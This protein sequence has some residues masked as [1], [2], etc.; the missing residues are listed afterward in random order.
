MP[1]LCDGTS[2]FFSL[3]IE[4]PPSGFQTVLSSRI[5]A[6]A[7][8]NLYS[9]AAAARKYHISCCSAALQYFFGGTRDRLASLIYLDS[10]QWYIIIRTA[11]RLRSKLQETSLTLVGLALSLSQSLYALTLVLPISEPECLLRIRE[12]LP[13]I[14]PHRG[15]EHSHCSQ[16]SISLVVY[17][18]I[19]PSPKEVVFLDDVWTLFDCPDVLGCMLDHVTH[20]MARRPR[21]GQYF[22][23]CKNDESSSYCP[24][25]HQIQSI[26]G[27]WTTSPWLIAYFLKDSGP[28]TAGPRA[29]SARRSRPRRSSSDDIELS[30]RQPSNPPV[31]SLPDL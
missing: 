17:S 15:L 2:R 22:L 31:P 18:N 27:T 14:P 8:P 24:N 19:S 21:D 3:F 4:P 9:H 16:C 5:D 30:P 1:A 11:E 7:G 10:W 29:Q 20:R 26:F 6:L 12:I 13:P 25:P 28:R 23:P